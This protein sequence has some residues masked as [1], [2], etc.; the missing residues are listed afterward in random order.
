MGKRVDSL[1]I[2]SFNTAMAQSADLVVVNG[3][4]D[5]YWTRVG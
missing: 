5:V 1:E 3:S 4:F 2:S